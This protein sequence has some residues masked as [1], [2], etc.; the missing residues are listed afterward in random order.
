MAIISCPE[1]KEPVSSVAASCPKC[2]YPISNATSLVPIVEKAPVFPA[3]INFNFYAGATGLFKPLALACNALDGSTALGAYPGS[4]IAIHRLDEGI[5]VH[6]LEAGIVTIH[7]AQIA[8]IKF[9][10]KVKQEAKNKSVIGRAVFGAVLLGPLGAVV[11]GISGA[12][13]KIH[14]HDGFVM[15]YWDIKRSEYSLLALESND[16]KISSLFSMLQKGSTPFASLHS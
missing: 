3:S 16:S 1:C 10:E 4:H 12:G 15:R 11:G 14:T 8:S 5:W 6:G 13:S 9:L 2:G 7:F